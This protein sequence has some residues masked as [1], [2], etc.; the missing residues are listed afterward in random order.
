ME[1]KS[2]QILIIKTYLTYLFMT[3]NSNQDKDVAEEADD[4]G[5]AVDENRPDQL[6]GG[7]GGYEPLFIVLVY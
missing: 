3:A 1:R 6:I 4:E 2:K 5:D 7:D